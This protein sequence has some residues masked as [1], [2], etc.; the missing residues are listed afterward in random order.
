MGFHGPKGDLGL[1]GPPGPPGPPGQGQLVSK[2]EAIVGPQGDRGQSGEKVGVDCHDNFSLFLQI[3]VFT[4]FLADFLTRVAIQNAAYATCSFV[5][6]SVCL[7]VQS[8]AVLKRSTVIKSR[9]LPVDK[10]R[11]NTAV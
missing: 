6:L 8:R 4:L 5:C 3:Y 1:P 2:G 9:S 11:G 10:P 7:S